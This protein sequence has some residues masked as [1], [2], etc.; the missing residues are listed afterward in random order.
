MTKIIV[1]SGLYASDAKGEFGISEIY[2]A[3]HV[4]KADQKINDKQNNYLSK[5]VETYKTQTI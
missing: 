3:G 5:T 2:F 4:F 1:R